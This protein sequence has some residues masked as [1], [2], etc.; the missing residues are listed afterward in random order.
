MK[1]REFNKP[2]C[3]QNI[4][5]STLVLIKMFNLVQPKCSTVVVLY[6]VCCTQIRIPSSVFYIHEILFGAGVVPC[7]RYKVQHL[8]GGGG[9]IPMPII[10]QRYIFESCWWRSLFEASYPP[11]E[12]WWWHVNDRRLW[13]IGI[14]K[15]SKRFHANTSCHGYRRYLLILPNLNPSSILSCI[16][17]GVSIKGHNCY[18]WVLNY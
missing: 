7:P 16:Y 4:Y 10:S 3:I 2:C 1:S 12:S 18:E 13:R 6:N 17:F 9:L 15:K 14:I 11:E 8:G 5:F